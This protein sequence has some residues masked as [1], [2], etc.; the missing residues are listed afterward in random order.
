MEVVSGF[1]QNIKCY[2]GRSTW[3][4]L[5]GRIVFGNA[6]RTQSVV[7]DAI[8]TFCDK[9]AYYGRTMCS[10]GRNVFLILFDAMIEVKARLV[11]GS[12]FLAGECIECE[13][14][15]TNISNNRV[16]TSND[17]N[18]ESAQKSEVERLAWASAQ[19]H[20]QCSVN[21]SRVLIPSRMDRMPKKMSMDSDASCTS[22]VPSRGKRRMYSYPWITLLAYNILVSFDC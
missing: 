20:C 16:A 2:S 13:I 14:I 12:V 17:T 1:F 10:R 18:S 8:P 5:W 22:F 15:F 11:R 21:E 7:L 9:S 6:S 3:R 4:M 19:L